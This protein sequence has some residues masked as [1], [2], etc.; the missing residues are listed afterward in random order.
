MPPPISEPP[1]F[2]HLREIAEGKR[3]KPA[4]NARRHHYVPSFLLARWALPARREGTMFALDVTTGKPAKTTPDASAFEKDLYAQPGPTG[5]PND[6]ELVFEAFLSIVEGYAA[7]PLKKLATR[8]STL[9]DEDRATLAYF[10]A[11]QQGRTPPGLAQHRMNAQ[12][13]ADAMF[14]AK[15]G[16]R[17]AVARAYRAK[18]NRD[19]DDEEIERFRLEQSEAFKQGT[20]KVTIPPEVALGALLTMVA[21]IAAVIATMDWIVLETTTGEFVTCD[22]AMSM[23]DPTPRYPWTGNA[24]QSSPNAETAVPLAP[25]ACLLIV[26]GGEGFKVGQA[27]ANRVEEINLRSYGW[28]EHSI[29]GSREQVVCGVSAAAETSPEAVTSPRL[30]RLVWMT[31][32]DP[33]DPT[34]GRNNADRGWPRGF[35][36]PDTTRGRRFVTYRVGEEMQPGNHTGGLPSRAMLTEL[37]AAF[38]AGAKP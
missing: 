21:E 4:T 38:E 34:V 5:D 15:M 20:V 22:R 25:N 16:D 26:P 12:R 17:G 31:D 9:G 32:A 8:P 3:P 10:I 35:W 19:A 37:R 6:P 28:A 2:K 33:H 36:V 24:W 23:F 11:V 27:D 1:L 18:M 14:V 7:D 13:T 29:F 30:P